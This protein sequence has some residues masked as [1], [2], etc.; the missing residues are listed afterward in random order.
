[1]SPAPHDKGLKPVALAWAAR[2]AARKPK[3]SAKALK[4]DAPAALRAVLRPLPAL[5][6]DDTRV[7]SMESRVRVAVA[8][9]VI[10]SATRKMTPGP[11]ALVQATRAWL[12]L[13]GRDQN[14]EALQELIDQARSLQAR[15][16][17]RISAGLTRAACGIGPSPSDTAHRNDD[18]GPLTTPHTVAVAHRSIEAAGAVIVDE[19]ILWLSSQA[20]TEFR[21]G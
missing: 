6:A 13:R 3:A 16:R 20:R 14:D 17:A 15:A 10:C 19:A 18:V 1:M 8:L 4:A 11:L 21:R 9:D 2:T 5:P 7:L 12:T